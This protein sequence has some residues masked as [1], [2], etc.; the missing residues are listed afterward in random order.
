MGEGGGVGCDSS[1]AT[2]G[3]GGPGGVLTRDLPERQHSMCSS[4]RRRIQRD[5]SEG[6]HCVQQC[7]L[8]RVVMQYAPPCALPCALPYNAL[9]C[10]EHILFTLLL[11][12][13]LPRMLTVIC[14]KCQRKH[15][16][17]PVC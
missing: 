7:K 3:G 14:L 12:A 8:C 17:L 16:L 11:V 15:W 1:S 10:R 9:L 6:Q 4:S 13:K 5:L 2:G